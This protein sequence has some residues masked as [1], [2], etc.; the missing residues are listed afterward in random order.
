MKLRVKNMLTDKNYFNETIQ[1]CIDTL[2][3]NKDKIYELLLDRTSVVNI[4]FNFRPDEVVNMDI[5]WN[6][7]VYENEEI[8]NIKVEGDKK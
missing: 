1:S 6:K 5:R 7:L 8:E 4:T 3:R 2:N